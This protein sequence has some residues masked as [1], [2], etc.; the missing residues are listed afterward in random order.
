MKEFD[1]SFSSSF[2]GIKEENEFEINTNLNQHKNNNVNINLNDRSLSQKKKEELRAKGLTP[3]EIENL[4]KWSDE[5][6]DIYGY[7]G[8]YLTDKQ[9]EAKIEAEIAKKI[10]KGKKEEDFDKNR[11]FQKYKADQDKRMR[12]NRVK[13]YLYEK[14][15]LRR[16]E[17]LDFSGI[18]TLTFENA[19][20]MYSDVYK[21]KEF[22][23]GKSREKAIKNKK[24]RLFAKDAVAKKFEEQD[25]YVF[26]QRDD[27][28][29][30]RIEVSDKVKRSIS[31][32]MLRDLSTLS[33]LF[34]SDNKSRV[35]SFNRYT[36]AFS[37]TENKKDMHGRVGVLGDLV[38]AI[39]KID[40]KGIDFNNI[41]TLAVK[42]AFF[43]K[44]ISIVEIAERM[45]KES[46]GF[47]ESLEERDRKLIEKKMK[48]GKAVGAFYKI[49]KQI[50]LNPYYRT[51]YN[52]EIS[53][54]AS[55]TDTP[56]KRVLSKLLRTAY[57]LA[58]NLNLMRIADL[59]GRES[60]PAN[61]DKVGS[62][63]E[64][65][66]EYTRKMESEVSVISAIEDDYSDF[67]DTEVI[68]I[69][70][71]IGEYKGI[72]KEDDFK[73]D[74]ARRRLREKINSKYGNKTYEQRRDD[75]VEQ[76]IR[77][78]SC[79]VFEKEKTTGSINLSKLAKQKMTKEQLI[80]S[81]CG[82]KEVTEKYVNYTVVN[83]EFETYCNN[84]MT[85]VN[86]T[87]IGLKGDKPEYT[88]LGD[89]ISRLLTIFSG[90]MYEH[91]TINERKEMVQNLVR[92]MK[93]SFNMD[94]LSQK[95]QEA[96]KR[97][98]W[99]A[100]HT[101][102]EGGYRTL[103]KLCN[104]I[105]NGLTFMHPEDILKIL[106][107]KVAACLLRHTGS[108]NNVCE[109]GGIYKIIGKLGEKCEYLR[110]IEPMLAYIS[111][112]QMTLGNYSSAVA[113]FKDDKTGSPES[114]NPMNEGTNGQYKD[115][116]MEEVAEVKDQKIEELNS[117]LERANGEQKAAIE[118]E[119]ILWEGSDEIEKTLPG[120]MLKKFDPE[121]SKEAKILQSSPQ[122]QS[123][124]ELRLLASKEN[125]MKAYL[126]SYLGIDKST[127]KEEKK[128]ILD[129]FKNNPKKDEI[130]N[131]FKERYD[132]II[133]P[134]DQKTR[135][136]YLKTIED[137]KL[138]DNK[139]WDYG[140]KDLAKIVL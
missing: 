37:E 111:G 94:E 36:A 59:E 117:K 70:K 87:E 90:P 105:Q 41:G 22:G 27:A 51:H 136:E 69:K 53:M 97:I 38:S 92:T 104:Y 115:A 12:T 114:F 83:K 118:K 16:I 9:I 13:R 79:L 134:V 84:L 140:K 63:K 1:E 100:Y 64:P 101:Y 65:Q 46:P 76:L 121:I 139:Q 4:P 116:C 108:F 113:Y 44:N 7:F 112:I 107:P 6:A 35:D 24:S 50:M 23:I 129:E 106:T 78:S 11:L 61:E 39:M 66:N 34:H 3:E 89:N 28:A 68:S 33:V 17:K 133:S 80:L 2:K 82:T 81:T 109:Y 85:D 15:N 42:A 49:E 10:A 5:E 95:E 122:A 75:L 91:L 30:L 119:I 62:L 43:E 123:N 71:E 131:K 93:N 135:Q 18:N 132:E 21:E 72:G 55:A 58:K 74:E 48:Q 99:D 137:R 130:M 67:S 54:N 14:K 60:I 45:F 40:Y 19:G 96:E 86:T 20:S 57:Y 125:G 29:K 98:F 32:Q 88:I 138:P 126:E 8:E 77:E 25:A 31:P 110:D 120:I 103:K 73:V 47:L 128:R 127:T 52:E 26:A 124:N 102:L 56:D